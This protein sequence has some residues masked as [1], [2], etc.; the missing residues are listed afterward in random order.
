MQCATKHAEPVRGDRSRFAVSKAAELV[1]W[2]WILGSGAAAQKLPPKTTDASD[3]L[4]AAIEI[5]K[6]SVGSVDCLA[7]SGKETKMLKRIGSAFLF[8]EAGDFL[9]AAHVVM[10]IQKGNDPC[11]TSAITLPLADWQPEARTEDMLW[12][13]FKNSDCK[14]D[15]TVD[16][17]VCRAS[18]N[19]PG[20]IRQLHLKAAPVQCQSSLPPDGAQLAFTGF[21][22]EARDPM[23]FRAHVA[24]Y[25]ASGEEMA[26]EL[27][28]D[29]A[30]LPGFS[31]SPVF[32]A[33]G[34]VFGILVR[35]GK[36]E[37]AGTAV[38]RPVSTFRK[39][40]GEKAPK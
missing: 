26:P 3:P 19:L 9:T 33:N 28:I 5:I 27:I 12:F 20:R 36:P 29:H 22:L 10:E 24:A 38:V 7:V 17:A 35:D 15:T 23:T 6:H 39:M 11:P 13:P 21:P 1:A 32:G 40:L 31:G 34:K 25:R 16:V 8:S 30:S 37:A 18:G 14:L 2:F 4:I